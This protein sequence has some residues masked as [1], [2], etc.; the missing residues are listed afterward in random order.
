MASLRRKDRHV[1]GMI[2]IRG[3]TIVLDN[4]DIVE[5]SSSKLQITS[6]G[7]AEEGIDRLPVVLS[8]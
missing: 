2:S 3:N 4:R 8:H 5:R 7:L 1:K 6:R